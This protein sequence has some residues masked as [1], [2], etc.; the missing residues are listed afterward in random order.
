MY[1]MNLMSLCSEYS[2]RRKKN[3]LSRWSL[4]M[5][6]HPRKMSSTPDIFEPTPFTPNPVGGQPTHLQAWRI[7][8]SK[9]EQVRT[10]GS[11]NRHTHSAFMTHPLRPS[12]GFQ[13][14]LLLPDGFAI[15]AF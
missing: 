14:D 9:G 10:P 12:V 1:V 3:W 5:A 4:V 15:V 7:P 13:R 8:S 11:I 2:A 6:L